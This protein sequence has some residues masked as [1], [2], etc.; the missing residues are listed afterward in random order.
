MNPVTGTRTFG[1]RSRAAHANRIGEI[2]RSRGVKYFYH[3]EQDNYRYFNDPAHPELD[4]VHRIQ[5]VMENTDPASLRV[6]DRHPAQLVGP[7]PLPERDHAPARHQRVGARPGAEPPRA[8]L[9]RQGRLP[10]HRANRDLGRRPAGERRSAV[11]PDVRAHG[12]VHRRGRV[13]RGR[14]GRGARPRPPE[15]RSGLPRASSSCSRTWA[16]PSAST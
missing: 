3:P 6:A 1:F 15:R 12:D 11:L 2:L 7:R 4:T 5:W 16:V 14:L 8:R 10:E 13:G 9:A